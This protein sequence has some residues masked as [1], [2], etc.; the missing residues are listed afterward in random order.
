MQSDEAAHVHALAVCNAPLRAT[1]GVLR[2][3]ARQ[4]GR[5]GTLPLRGQHAAAGGPCALAMGSAG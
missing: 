3:G 1:P 5:D 2:G 4:R